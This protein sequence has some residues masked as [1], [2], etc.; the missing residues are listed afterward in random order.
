M[1]EAIIQALGQLDVENDYHWTADGLPVIE[2][3][4]ELMG[5]NVTRAEIT[6]AAKGFSRKT[7][8]M[9]GNPGP[10]PPSGMKW[11]VQKPETTSKP[12]SEVQAPNGGDSDL[13]V[14][15][16]GQ[17]DW[18]IAIEEN[19]QSAK[20]AFYQAKANLEAASD[21]KDR[22]VRYKEEIAVKVNP[23]QNIKLFQKAQMEQRQKRKDQLIKA[24]EEAEGLTTKY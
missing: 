20:A 18:A 22:L 5:S 15:Q 4:K 24:R 8:G 11:A 13:T 10:P 21:Q 6:D 2:V 3:M 14:E 12:E 17:E 16:V 9:L 23:S 19:F 1:R 7:T